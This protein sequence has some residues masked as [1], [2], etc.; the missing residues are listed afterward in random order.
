MFPYKVPR[1]FS[2]HSEE[3]PNSL[4][5]LTTELMFVVFVLKVCVRQGEGRTAI[6]LVF[7]P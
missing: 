5:L 6:F 3:D 1:P 2:I 4:N 7:G